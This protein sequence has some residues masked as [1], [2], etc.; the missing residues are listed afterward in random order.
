[1]VINKLDLKKEIYIGESVYKIRINSR[2]L[3]KGKSG[4]LRSYLYLH[5]KEDAVVPLVIYAKGEREDISERELQSHLH[6]TI[7]E[8]LL[9]FR[10]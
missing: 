6:E 1:M 9:L 5:S 7:R 8:L 4:G 10:H 3:K 2:D